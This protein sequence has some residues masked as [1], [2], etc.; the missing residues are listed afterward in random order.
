[1]E[2]KCRWT[3]GLATGRADVAGAP[4][5][6]EFG[7]EAEMGSGCTDWLGDGFCSLSDSM[8]IGF[9]YTE[10]RTEMWQV[11]G[12]LFSGCVSLCSRVCL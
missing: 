6:L 5:H 9:L 1:M 7:R 12:D 10:S 8:D 2:A 3:S 11:L 4:A